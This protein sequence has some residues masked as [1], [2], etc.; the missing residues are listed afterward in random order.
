MT[1]IQAILDAAGPPRPRRRDAA[2]LLAK[3]PYAKPPR[4]EQQIPRIVSME[5]LNATYDAAKWMDVPNGFGVSP[6]K[7]WRALLSVA[8]NTALRRGSLFMLR[9]EYVDLE[10]RQ[11]VIPANRMKARRPHLVPLNSD[12][13]QHLQ[14]IIGNGQRGLVFPWPYTRETFGKRFKMLQGLAGIP[15]GERFGLHAIR[16]TA[17]S[18]LWK[19]SPEAAQIVL[20]HRS[21]LITLRHY[22][23]PHAAA[24]EGMER[25]TQPWTADDKSPGQLPQPD[26]FP[27]KPEPPEDNAAA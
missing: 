17:A 10:K 20:G 13:M 21:S 25:M 11:I 2:G 3:V 27:T 12:A 4:A 24:A 19:T 26:E 9:W 7:W 15:P 22:V 8:L 16:R 5:W 6:T 23:Q 1:Q 14:A 18:L